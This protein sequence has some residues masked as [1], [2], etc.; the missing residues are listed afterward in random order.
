MKTALMILI[1][2]PLAV[3]AGCVAEGKEDG[4]EGG[5]CPEGNKCKSGLVCMSGVCVKVPEIGPWTTDAALPVDARGCPDAK[6]CQPTLCPDGKCPTPVTGTIGGKCYPNMTCNTG[7]TCISGLCVRLPDGGQC[8]VCKDA[9]KCSDAKICPKPKDAGAC[10]DLQ[11]IDK[12]LLDSQSAPDSQ[13][14]D[15]GGQC[16]HP[17]VKKNCKKDMLGIEWCTIPAGCFLMGSG[18]RQVTLT[19]G[20]EISATEVQQGGGWPKQYATIVGSN[21]SVN[22]A[23]GATCPVENVAWHQAANYCNKLSKIKKLAECYT[24]SL[25]KCDIVK[26]YSGAKIYKCPGYRL[27]TEAEFE[28]ALRAGTQSDT[29]IGKLTWQN[30]DLISW[31]S[32]NS[33]WKTHPAGQKQPNAWGLHDMFGNVREWCHDWH[34]YSLGTSPVVDPWGAAKGTY[35]TVRGAGY[36]HD[37]KYIQAS[38]R[39]SLPLKSYSKGTGFRCVR[40]LA[41]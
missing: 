19:H 39:E 8:P 25:Y 15:G 30:A 6:T 37:L 36:G 33:S 21:P 40:T 12:A 26:N 34:Q 17:V 11:S 3:G 32:K 28:Y 29:Y 5:A 23:C 14:F 1:T 7:L 35:K 9:G 13:M 27:P 16:K 38:F 4:A 41:P 2:L 10:P 22:K 20:F 24:C 31:W 18:K